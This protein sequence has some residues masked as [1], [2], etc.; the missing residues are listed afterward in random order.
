MCL[1]LC[2]TSGRT[3]KDLGLKLGVKWMYKNRVLKVTWLFV[4][5]LTIALNPQTQSGRFG[6]CGV[7]G[8]LP[9]S[10]LFCMLVG[11]ACFVSFRVFNEVKLGKLSKT[12][13]LVYLFIY[14]I[15]KKVKT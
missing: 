13:L 7:H 15:I 9:R 6:C 14:V 4:M 2:K 3:L 10:Q 8:V 12:N 11:T 1:Y 5:P